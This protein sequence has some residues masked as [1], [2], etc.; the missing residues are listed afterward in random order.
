MCRTENRELLLRGGMPMR[1]AF[2]IGHLA[3]VIVPAAPSHS[4]HSLARPN[5]QPLPH[6]PDAQHR[7]IIGRLPEPGAHTWPPWPPR[8]PSPWRYPQASFYRPAIMSLGPLGPLQ[9][10]AQQQCFYQTTITLRISVS[11]YRTKHHTTRPRMRSS[12]QPLITLSLC[13]LI[14]LPRSTFHHALP[15]SAGPVRRA[16]ASPGA[17]PPAAPPDHLRSPCGR[18]PYEPNFASPVPCGNRSTSPR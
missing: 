13:H 10:P 6:I 9:I 15:P 18:P 3:F 5:A 4:A 17:L 12:P 14:T 11:F 8:P 1:T 16:C 2:E 7:L